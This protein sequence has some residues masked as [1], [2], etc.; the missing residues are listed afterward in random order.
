M[1]DIE[2][3]TRELH[4]IKGI[5][6]A[7]ADV[8]VEF[9]L[10]NLTAAEPF[11]ANWIGDPSKLCRDRGTYY[12]GGIGPFGLLV[13]ASDTLEENTAIY[14]RVFREEVGGGD[15]KVLMC[16]DSRK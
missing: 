6:A 1:Q 2:L 8:E 13:L 12:N 15:Y 5:Q 7:Q 3:R 11:H 14:F 10:P 9:Q 4:E 16:T